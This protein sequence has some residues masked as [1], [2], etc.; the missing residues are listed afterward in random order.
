V[1]LHHVPVGTSTV[2]VATVTEVVPGP[3]GG[4]LIYHDR[5]FITAPPQAGP[6]RA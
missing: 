4:R 3:P 5:R 2:V 6:G 1:P